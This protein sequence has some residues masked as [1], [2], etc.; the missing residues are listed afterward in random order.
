M[1]VLVR[2][3]VCALLELVK[4][5]WR[6]EKRQRGARES[7]FCFWS[8]EGPKLVFHPIK[9][10][11]YVVVAASGLLRFCS[12][13]T[14]LIRSEKKKK[15]GWG[16]WAETLRINS[17]VDTLKAFISLSCWFIHSIMHLYSMWLGKTEGQS[18]M[19]LCII[20]RETLH[21]SH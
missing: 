7:G 16:N 21:Q 5:N 8:F 3:P 6:W 10:D 17:W 15:E 11:V 1:Q 12:P 4:W 19:N 18:I 9:K 20:H 13:K 2:S 14:F